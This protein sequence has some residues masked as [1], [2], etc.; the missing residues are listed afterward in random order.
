[1]S[2]KIERK[3]DV[4]EFVR[5]YDMLKTDEQKYQ[6]VESVIWRKYCP[7]LEKKVILQSMLD[8]TI[9]TNEN[10]LS[11]IDYFLSKVNI[12]TAILLL[13]TKLN[14]QKDDE[15]DTTAFDDYD[16]L[17]ERNLFNVICEIIGENELNE[18]M[19]VNELLINNYTE[20]N[21]T[22]EAYISKYVNLFSTTVGLFANEGANQLVNFI[23]ENDILHNIK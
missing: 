23:K 1:M 4:K 12:V 21:K 8:K 2:E 20:E 18:L 9:V 14:I 11:H 13:Y 6:F 5:R 17:V 19:T 10:K 15:S 7:I 22:M 16:M 3:I